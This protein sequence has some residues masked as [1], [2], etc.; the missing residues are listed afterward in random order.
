MHCVEEGILCYTETIPKIPSLAGGVFCQKAVK[1]QILHR[2][3][4]IST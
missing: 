1:A 4:P 3:K 2:E